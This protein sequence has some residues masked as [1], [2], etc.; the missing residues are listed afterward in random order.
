[1]HAWARVD[2]NFQ[3][4]PKE[5]LLVLGQHL[6]P[7]YAVS[8]KRYGAIESEVI[9]EFEGA[10]PSISE[11]AI[12]GGYKITKAHA[13]VGFDQI[14]STSSE[15]DPTLYSISLELAHYKSG[16]IQRFRRLTMKVRATDQ[17]RYVF[18]VTGSCE[19]SLRRSPGPRSTD[20]TNMNFAL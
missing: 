3:Q 20:T 16:P 9:L 10:L 19:G 8:H 5:I 12:L 1:M 2:G 14:I 18:D 15:S 4:R 13:S 17:Y 11:A 7:T 6:T